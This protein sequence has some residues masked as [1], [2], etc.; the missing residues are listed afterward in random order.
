MAARVFRYALVPVCL[1]LIAG[2]G[3][4]AYPRSFSGLRSCLEDTQGLKEFTAIPGSQLDART[5]LSG[6]QQVLSFESG[7]PRD[8][9]GTDVEAPLYEYDLYV[10]P[11]GTA[12]QRGANTLRRRTGNPGQETPHVVFA[13]G[14]GLFSDEVFSITSAPPTPSASI[15]DDVRTCLRRTGFA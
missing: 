7:G 4:T 11:D 13:L 2:C 1:L 8:T 9:D 6:S 14:R 10:F 15:Q 5:A 12:A 3:S